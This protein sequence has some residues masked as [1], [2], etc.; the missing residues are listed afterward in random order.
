M[1]PLSTL[2][3]PTGT[4]KDD[5]NHYCHPPYMRIQGHRATANE[6]W[7]V[8]WLQYG[9]RVSSFAVFSEEIAPHSQHHDVDIAPTFPMSRMSAHAG[10]G[11]SQHISVKYYFFWGGPFRCKQVSSGHQYVEFSF[12]NNSGLCASHLVNLLS[13]WLLRHGTLIVHLKITG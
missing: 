2:S 11:S 6:L 4:G 13:W 9:G 12:V 3:N 5:M 10:V 8:S 7:L 1:V